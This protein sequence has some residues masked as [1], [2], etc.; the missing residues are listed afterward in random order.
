MDCQHTE[1]CLIYSNKQDLCLQRVRHCLNL[2]SEE[3]E[4]VR[5]ATQPPNY[6]EQSFRSCESYN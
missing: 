1:E 3:R 5:Q 2:V 6:A 4:K